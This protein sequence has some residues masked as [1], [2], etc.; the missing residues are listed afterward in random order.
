MLLL[1]VTGNSASALEDLSES[2]KLIY[3]TACQCRDAV[4]AQLESLLKSNRLNIG[5]LFDTFYVPIPNT[6]PQKY[7]TQ[8]DK[9]TDPVLRIILDQYL[10]KNNKFVFVIA[11]DKNGYV[12]THNS[13]YS[14]PLTGNANI[15]AVNNRTKRIFND[16]TGLAA[17][18]NTAPYLLQQY[19]RD[20]GEKMADM[21]VPVYIQGKHWGAIRIG[22]QIN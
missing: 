8:Y 22:Y 5:Q 15:D 11:V 12:P 19:S 10:G 13:K 14:R 18:K 1:I 20:T 6:N 16:R 17:A 21:S 3:Q 2:D 9:I 7:S 4:T